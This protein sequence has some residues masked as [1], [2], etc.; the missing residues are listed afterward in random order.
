M[1]DPSMTDLMTSPSNV[2]FNTLEDMQTALLERTD[3]CN[4]LALKIIE[5]ENSLKT[6]EISRDEFKQRYWSTQAGI[7]QFE[8]LLKSNTEDFHE[9]LIEDICS[10]FGFNM[11]KEYD[12][13]R[14]STRL[15]SSH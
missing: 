9:S 4:T 5:L 6:M 1:I 14:K 10:I 3:E 8:E 2:A 11:T 15:N 7:D 13:D 12:V